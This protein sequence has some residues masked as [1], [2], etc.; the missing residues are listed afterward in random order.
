MK[1]SSKVFLL[2]CLSLF[3]LLI[4]PLFTYVNAST[5][6]GFE[7]MIYNEPFF[8]FLSILYF[9]L[10]L[11]EF[12]SWIFISD[13]T[14]HT[15]FII[16]LI[17]FQFLMYNLSLLNVHINI[18]FEYIITTICFYLSIT[19]IF[20]YIYDFY[21]LKLHAYDYSL[22][23][24]GFTNFFLQILFNTN[25]YSWIFSLISY[26]LII[27]EA[28]KI[29]YVFIKRN[30][31]NITI[32]FIFIIC[33]MLIDINICSV[34]KYHLGY[35]IN[36]ATIL[37]YFIIFCLFIGIYFSFIVIN[38]KRAIK[39]LEFELELNKQETY[40][41]EKQIEPHF[42][43]NTLFTIKNS[44]HKSTEDGD[45]VL[46]LF[47]KV[48]RN[49]IVQLK[50]VLIPFSNELESIYDYVEIINAKSDKKFN[51]ILNIDEDEFLIPPLSIHIYVENAIKYSKV[52]ETE[53]GYIIIT[54]TFNKST[55]FPAY[56]IEIEDNGIGFD[57]DKVTSQS[58]GIQNSKKRLKNLLDARIDIYSH[59][60]VGTK[61]KIT[62]PVAGGG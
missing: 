53:N 20:Y 11:I 25:T 32:F 38:N 46:D 5:N 27:T 16:L 50:E 58:Y 22:I 33:G 8:I 44:Y 54:S 30:N 3:T 36:S 60:N 49:N 9:V 4:G 17:F 45:Y 42:I 47:S 61:I 34:L 14:H 41:L 35:V 52:N 40:L 59:P 48:L 62:I 26:I 10:I 43:F 15:L 21:K 6:H 57:L 18:R 37:C 7:S 51:L 19:S 2:I 1:N 23:G 29:I 56:I 39:A 31:F 13:S 55:Y 24:I 12:L 28:I